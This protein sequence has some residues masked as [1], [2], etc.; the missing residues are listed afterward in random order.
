MN[1]LIIIG[2][3]ISAFL[4]LPIAS[5][6]ELKEIQPEPPSDAG[7]NNQPP[8]PSSNPPSII[9]KKKL[10]WAW[11]Y[12]IRPSQQLNKLYGQQGIPVI[13]VTQKPSVIINK[14]NWDS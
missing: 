8:L 3:F 2:C 4:I 13:A 10:N 14:L 7:T 1:I 6:W 12:V 11:G 9:K 5:H